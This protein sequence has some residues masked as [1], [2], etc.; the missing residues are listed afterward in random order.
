MVPVMAL[1][2]PERRRSRQPPEF[3]NVV[4]ARLRQI[5]TELGLTQEELAA[6]CQVLGLDMARGTLAKIEARVRLLKA[7]ELFI[8]A[9]VLKL[10]MEHFYPAD[11]GVP[12]TNEAAKPSVRCRPDA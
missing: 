12:V 3:A 5:R 1:K 4:G 8:I 7:C 6:R 9:K 11:F 10:P 2:I